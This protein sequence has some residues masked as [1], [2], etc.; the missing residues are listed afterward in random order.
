MEYPEIKHITHDVRQVLKVLN[1]SKSF[2]LSVKV[3]FKYKSK[4]I[5]EQMKFIKT[6]DF[7]K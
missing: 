5:K 2:K 6:N 4:R 7:C 1:N 3:L